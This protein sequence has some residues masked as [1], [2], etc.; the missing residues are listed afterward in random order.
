MPNDLG[1]VWLDDHRCR[2]RVWAPASDRV[3]L[4]LVSPD[5]SLSCMQPTQLGYHTTTLEGIKPGARYFY[6]L[7]NGA[8]LPDPAS[9][10]QPDGVMGPSEVVPPHF[11]W[12]DKYWLGLLIENYILYELHVGTFTREGTFDAI[13]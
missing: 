5:D 6:R 12:T 8:E 1:A 7:S 4:H 3:H 11:E 9:R 13:I 2:F 10:Y